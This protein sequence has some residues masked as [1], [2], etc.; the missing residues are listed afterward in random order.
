MSE[1]KA[2]ARRKLDTSERRPSP[3]TGRCVV[4][5][6]PPLLDLELRRAHAWLQIQ[7]GRTPKSEETFALSV[8]YMALSSMKE[9]TPAAPDAPA[10]EPAL[11]APGVHGDEVPGGFCS[12]TLP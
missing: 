1:S 11:V 12:G 8:L 3:V 5:T 9:T 2:R 7:D 10:A 6:L 4:W